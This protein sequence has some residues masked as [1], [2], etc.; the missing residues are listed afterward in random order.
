MEDFRLRQLVSDG[1]KVLE[2]AKKYGYESIDFQENIGMA[3]FTK[4]DVRI[5][6]Y[7]T[8]RTVGTCLNHPS[9]GKTQLFR[10]NCSWDEIEMIFKN[11]RT[12]TSKG[13]Y[14]KP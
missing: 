4:A 11:P 6:V 13:Y 9:K 8:K 2:M 1:N 14:Q 7:L 10:K 5:N 12:H 3:S